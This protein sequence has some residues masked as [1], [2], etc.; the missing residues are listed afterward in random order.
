MMMSGALRSGV[1]VGLL[2]LS[3]GALACSPQMPRTPE[4]LAA[5]QRQ[6]DDFKAHARASAIVYGVLEKGVGYDDDGKFHPGKLGELRIIHVYRGTYQVGQRVV[7]RE[8][9]SPLTRCALPPVSLPKGAY[10]IAI[11][12]EPT[13]GSPVRH[14]GFLP[15]YLVA[16]FLK[17]GIIQSARSSAR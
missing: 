2:G 9:G 5:E 4:R 7:V 3:T 13:D 17:D 16:M 14:N 8:G 11:L 15:E 1:F 10:G 12:D 6:L